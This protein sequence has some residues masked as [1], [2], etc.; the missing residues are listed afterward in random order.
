MNEKTIKLPDGHTWVEVQSSNAAETTFEC[1][2]GASFIHDG[3][4]G[5]CH[6]QNGDGSCDDNETCSY[7]GCGLF[8]ERGN[9]QK[10]GL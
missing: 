7:C 2:C 10:C 6:F 9:C 4:D 5:S 3:I 1:K 8:D